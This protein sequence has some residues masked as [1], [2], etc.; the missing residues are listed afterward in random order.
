MAKGFK[1]HGAYN[2]HRGDAS[3][4]ESDKSFLRTPFAAAKER[5]AASGRNF[6]ASIRI[7][8]ASVRMTAS[9]SIRA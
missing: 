3:A 9:H 5:T 4:F 8:P 7:A 2:T 1:S 6:P